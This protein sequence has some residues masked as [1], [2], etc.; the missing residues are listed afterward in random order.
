MRHKPGAPK[1]RRNVMAELLDMTVQEPRSR[2]LTWR[3]PDAV[4]KASTGYDARQ[5]K[6]GEGDR[7]EEE[8]NQ[9]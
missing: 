6:G 3:A 2:I 7:Q 8:P 5:A 4:P 1:A 9:G